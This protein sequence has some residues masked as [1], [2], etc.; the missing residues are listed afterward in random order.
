VLW[1]LVLAPTL[2]MGITVLVVNFFSKWGQPVKAVG[3]A[4]T[5]ACCGLVSRLPLAAAGVPVPEVWPFF[6][7]L[8][9]FLLHRWPMFL[10]VQWISLAMTDMANYTLPPALLNNSYYFL[11]EQTQLEGTDYSQ[12]FWFMHALPQIRRQRA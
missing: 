3:P 9:F 4:V 8:V 12:H 5:I 10:R 7:V 11:P 1:G 2:G 6:A